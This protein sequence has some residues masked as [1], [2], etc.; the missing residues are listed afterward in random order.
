MIMRNREEVRLNTGRW[1][2]YLRSRLDFT[3]VIHLRSALVVRSGIHDSGL[4]TRRG[5]PRFDLGH[6]SKIYGSHS[7]DHSSNRD[8]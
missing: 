6:P 7:L 8:R 1:I 4:M 2:Q 3:L 5:T